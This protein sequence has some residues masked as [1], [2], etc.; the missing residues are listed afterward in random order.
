MPRFKLSDLRLLLGLTPDA[1]FNTPRTLIAQLVGGKADAHMPPAPDVNRI[2]DAMVGGGFPRSQKLRAGWWKPLPWSLGGRLNC[3][4]AARLG[5]RAMGGPVTATPVTAGASYDQIG[6]CPAII[7][8][9]FPKLSTL[10]AVLGGYDYLYPSMAANRFMITFNGTNNV[11]FAADLINTGFFAHISSL[12][13]A[14]TPP[15]APN[16]HLMH[17]AAVRVTFDGGAGTIDY[18]L[19]GDLISGSCGIDNAIEVKQVP[20][21]PF[22]TSTDRKSGAYARELNY[23]DRVPVATLRAALRNDL[24]QFMLAQQGTDITN[25]TFLF[26]GED[27]IGATSEDYEYELKAPLAQIESVATGAEG[28]NAATDITFYVKTDPLTHNYWIPR[29]RTGEAAVS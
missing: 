12:V 18:A 27:K 24:Q 16:H 15:D 22:F 14:I 1:A 11:D 3:E 17:P 21:D 20:G 6:A 28:N 19:D 5:L 26:R 23:G 2:P 7:N 8:G 9:L 4:T 29:V 10:G 13:P 25:L